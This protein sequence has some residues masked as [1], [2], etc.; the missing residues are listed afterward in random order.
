MQ[1]SNLHDFI[2]MGGYADYVWAAYGVVFIVL[3]GN[4][5]IAKRQ[6]INLFR[7]LRK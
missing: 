7:K 3:I 1:F 4:L 6:K 2:H 5:F